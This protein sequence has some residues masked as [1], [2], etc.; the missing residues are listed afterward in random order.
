MIG[1]FLTTNY[2]WRWA[3]GI[4]VII[5]PSPSSGPCCSSEQRATG[6]RTAIDLPGGAL[7]A[8]GT[9]PSSSP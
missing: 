9:F 1:G 5:A 6:D 2:S 8:C 7:I 4:N 3:F